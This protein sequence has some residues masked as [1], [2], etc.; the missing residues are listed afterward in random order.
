MDLD[1]DSLSDDGKELA[2]EVVALSDDEHHAPQHQQQRKRK[3]AES[4][5]IVLHTKRLQ[6]IV[7]KSCSCKWGSACRRRWREPA[8][9]QRLLH[10]R[11]RLHCMEKRQADLEVRCWLDRK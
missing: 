4:H 6:A 3:F 10:I 1:V 11:I 7:A 2:E 8:A 5:D 9:F